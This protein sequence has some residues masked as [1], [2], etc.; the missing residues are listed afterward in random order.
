M[1][2]YFRT[3]AVLTVL[4]AFCAIVALW[5]AIERRFGTPVMI[6]A[7]ILP[8]IAPF[9]V[10]GLVMVGAAFKRKPLRSSNQPRIEHLRIAGK[11]QSVGRFGETGISPLHLRG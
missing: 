3:V 5:V 8:F 4:V 6:A 7:N 9:V 1:K 10:L 11:Y 2:K